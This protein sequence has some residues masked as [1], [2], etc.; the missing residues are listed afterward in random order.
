MIRVSMSEVL[1]SDYMEMTNL[2]DLSVGRL[3][4]VHAICLKVGLFTVNW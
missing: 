3:V 1:G 2:K 4:F